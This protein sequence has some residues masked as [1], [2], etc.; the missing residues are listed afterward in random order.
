MSCGRPDLRR[1]NAYVDGELS[2]AEAAEVARALA[3]DRELARQVATLSHLKATVQAALEPP[4]IALPGGGA[5]VARTRHAAAL[6]ACAAVLLLAVIGTALGPWWSGPAVPAGLARA[7]DLH[8]AWSQEAVASD[9]DA[10]GDGFVLAALAQVGPRVYL[11]DL[12]SA[13]LT[14]N[15]LRVVDLGADGAKGLHAGYLGTRGCQI[16][17]IVAPDAPDLP[18]ELTRYEGPKGQSYAWRGGGHGYFLL[19]EGMDA[20]RFG[21]IA[22]SVYRASQEM[23]PFG[24][25]T[26]TALRESRERS[27]PCHA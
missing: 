15:S 4:Q 2:S 9:T 5:S 19:A 11:P 17:L 20:A 12:S 21:L 7:W 24:P 8:A 1:I 23:N 27:V 14:L 16:S 25:E 18:D 3:H 6:A 22:E 13:R 10:P 26:R